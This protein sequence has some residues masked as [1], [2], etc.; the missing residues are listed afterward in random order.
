MGAY[1]NG[2]ASKTGRTNSSAI[3][4]LVC[5][6]IQFCL[7]PAGL[8]AIV[9]GHQARRQIRRTGESGYGIATAG[10]VLGYLLIASTLLTLVIALSMS[11]SAAPSPP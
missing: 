8:V 11:S 4:A 9:L 5:G 7:P 10:L 6:I 2:Q 3:A 1:Y